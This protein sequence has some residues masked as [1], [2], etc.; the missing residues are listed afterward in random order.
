MTVHN[1]RDSLAVSHAHSDAPWW[2]DV[3]RTVFGDRLI[4]MIDL[5]D[6]GWAQRGGIDRQ[7]ILADGTVLKVDEKVRKEDWPDILL[8]IWSDEARKTPGWMLKPL[9]CDFIA[10]AFIPSRTCY[11]LPYQLLK[12]A[13]EKNKNEWWRDYGEPPG[14]ENLRLKRAKNR[15]Y[16][17][18][19]MAVPT[20]VL[21][22]AIASA[23]V[24]T[25]PK[26][27]VA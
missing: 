23:I 27:Q 18:A 8:E 13:F 26:Q 19:S 7:L 24:V 9:T 25:W 4:S 12:S 6:D 5:R 11:L 17:T 15:G 1:F 16:V 2:G 14:Y 20:A 3:Y 21:L 10:Y 22:D